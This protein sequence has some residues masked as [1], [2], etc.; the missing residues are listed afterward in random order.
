MYCHG[1]K[2][3]FIEGTG[4]P[5]GLFDEADY[6]ELN[7]KAKPGDLFVFYSDGILDARNRGGHSF[8]PERVA[9]IIA[10]CATKAADCVVS[11]IFMVVH[12]LA[13]GQDTF[14]LHTHS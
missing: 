2:I 7:F 8:G 13:T 10:S 11:D 5:V 9:A 12:A 6:D 3:E 14:V 4:L 1:G